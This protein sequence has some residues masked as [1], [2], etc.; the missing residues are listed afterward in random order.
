MR[1]I[2]SLIAAA[3]AATVI[4]ACGSSSGGAE[5]LP[6]TGT[7]LPGSTSHGLRGVELPSASCHQQSQQALT[8]A[9]VSSSAVT[10]LILCPL[11]SPNAASKRV[12]VDRANSHFNPI[13]RALADPDVP[14]PPSPL[15]CPMFANQ[16]Q[17]VIAV[18][19]HG[20]FALEIPVDVCRHYQPAALAALTAARG[21]AMPM[22]TPGGAS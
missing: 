14:A 19:P 22:S 11:V 7:V 21:A 10:S 17:L 16:T 4:A 18:T 6:G 20:A 15:P 5:Q 8:L 1:K 13:V 3:G 2:C 12:V 9:P